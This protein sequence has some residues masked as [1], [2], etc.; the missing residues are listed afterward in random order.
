MH[1]HD[2]AAAVFFLSLAALIYTFFGYGLIISWLA[3]RPAAEFSAPPNDVPPVCVILAA[4]NEEKN[5]VERVRNLFASDYPPEKLRVMVV[6]DGSV[7]ET[8]ARAQ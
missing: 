2:V 3:R 5:I 8:T 4:H 6:S 7:D 1:F